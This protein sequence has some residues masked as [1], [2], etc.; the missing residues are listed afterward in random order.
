M[1]AITPLSAF[2]QTPRE[3][4]DD[5]NPTIFDHVVYIDLVQVMGLERVVDHVGPIHVARR[6]E[7]FD[8][9]HFFGR[10]HTLV[11]QG[12]VVILFID[13]VVQVFGQRSRDFVRFRVAGNI[14]VSGPGND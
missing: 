4:V 2:H 14:G 9:R 5:D 11:R 3:F 13:G 8:T 7:T 1:Q 6:I 10:S 12:H